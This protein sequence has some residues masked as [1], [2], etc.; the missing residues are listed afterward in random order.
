ME[1]G[2]LAAPVDA[3][4]VS[5]WYDKHAR[6]LLRFCGRRVGP[7][8]AEDVVAATFLIAIERRAD[9][10]RGRSAEVLPWLYGIA[11]NVLRRHR[12][13]EE[14]AYRALARAGVDPLL[15]TDGMT[16]GPEQRVGERTDASRR[17]R[18]V[19]GVLA[20]LPRRQRDVLLLVAVGGLPYEDV[21]TAL[22][23]PIGSVRSA[24]HRARQKLRAVLGAEEESDE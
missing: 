3:D 19:A 15:R 18:A 16:D 22:G 6:E 8:L 4:L 10:D 12:R 7:E 2:I 20:A 5:G 24:L 21:A 23:I 9:F 14:R 17:T 1:H 13:D 11:T